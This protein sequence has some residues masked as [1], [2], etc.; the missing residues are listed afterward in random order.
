[1][2]TVY[3][4][5]YIALLDKWSPAVQYLQSHNTS[6]TRYLWSIVDTTKPDSPEQLSKLHIWHSE[7]LTCST[8]ILP[9]KHLSDLDKQIHNATF[10]CSSSSKYSLNNSVKV[11]SCKIPRICVKV[12]PYWLTVWDVGINKWCCMSVINRWME[13]GDRAPH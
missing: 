3:N 9:S 8:Y 2:I 11:D 7:W 12:G 4:A 5:Q 13:H 6:W 1:M 10:H